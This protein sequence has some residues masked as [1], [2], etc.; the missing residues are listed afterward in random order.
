[1]VFHYYVLLEWAQAV[2]AGCHLVLIN[3]LLSYQI[4][5][6]LIIKSNLLKAEGPDGH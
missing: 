2:M 3:S 4:K 6:K 1:M 5:S